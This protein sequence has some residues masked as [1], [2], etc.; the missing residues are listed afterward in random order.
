MVRDSRPIAPC[1]VDALLELLGWSDA[2][3]WWHHWQ[4]RGGV[5][6]MRDRWPVPVDDSWIAS[7][8][9][10]LLTRVEQAHAANGPTL[11][12]VSALPG[13]GKTTLCSWV[14]HASD[15]LGWSVDHLS[16]D[17]FYWPADQLDRSMAGNP[18]GVP[19]ALPGSHDLAGMERSLQ[20]WLQGGSLAAPRFDKSLRGGRG[21]RCG[22][23]IST[24][25]VVLLEGWFLGAVVGEHREDA[26]QQPLK[27]AESR[28]R[29][30]AL[31]QLSEYAPIWGMLNELWHLRIESSNA[32]A[33]WKRQQLNTLKY[34]TGVAFSEEELTGFNR[35]VE[36]A[37]PNS[38]LNCIPG[39]TVIVD[40]TNERM[41][42]EIRFS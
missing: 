25:K 8:A 3:R 20:T 30:H 42:R 11:I 14:K 12:G 15:H 35:M 5:N 36:V 13:C 19:R 34:S 22:S 2:E 37:L 6:L 1:G 31:R 4:A 10:P 40:L 29:P 24:P 7:L 18:W 16:I 39:A 32:S 17:D 9:L 23:T 33:D 21:D 41:I 28:W 26:L 38:C 27:P